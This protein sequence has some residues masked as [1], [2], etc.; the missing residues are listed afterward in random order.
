MSRPRHIGSRYALA[1]ALLCSSGCGSDRAAPILVPTGELAADAGESRYALVGE[2]VTLDGSASRGAVRYQ[3]DFGNGDRQPEPTGAPTV[4]VTFDAP[5]RYNAVL[6]VYDDAG[7]RRSDSVLITVTHPPVFAPSHSSTVAVLAG[8]DEVAVVSTDSSELTRFTWDAQGVLSLADRTATPAG[9]RTVTEWHSWLVVPCQDAGVV[10]FIPV[11]AGSSAISVTMPYGSRPY[12]AAGNDDAVFVSLSGTGQLARI[13][14]DASQTSASVTDTVDVAD[15]RGVALLPDGRVATVRWRSPDARA[16]LWAVDPATSAVDTWTLA[17]DPQPSS[18]TESGG[19][20]SYLDQLLVSP[21]G[22]E[23]VVPSLQANI[24]E[25]DF[26]TGKPLT[27]QSTV[28]AIISY[29]DPASGAEQRERRKQF[30]DRGFAAAAVFSSRGD[31]LYVAMPGAR[32]VDRIDVLGGGQSGTIL[33]V[34]YAPHGVALSSDDRYLFVDASL[35]RELVSYDVSDL[36]LPAAA[37][38]RAPI[39]AVEPLAPEVLV[40]KQLFS[41]SFDTRI[42]KDGYIA[43]AHCHLD[44]LDDRRVWDFTDRGEGLRSTISL[45]GRGGAAHGPIHW[46]SN[47][48]EVQD[49]EHDIRGPFAGTGLMSDADFHSGTRDQTLGEP[50]AGISEDLDALAAYV[51]FLDQFAPSPH[52]NGDGSLTAAAQSGKLLFESLTLGCTTCH[53]GPRLTDSQWVAPAQ[54]LLHDVG[55]LGPG[56]GQRLGGPLTGIDTPTLHGL[57]ASAPYLHDGSAA[58]LLDVLTT[59][60]PSDMHGTTSTLTQAELGDLVAYLLSL[61]GRVN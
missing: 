28:R 58:T 16:E 20:P 3:W 9:P 25:G 11:Q 14:V 39:V 45:A 56:S 6:T 32:A 13:E 29:L 26:V 57:W 44:G 10:M 60:N 5:G 34:G 35:S 46:S 53:S 21:T 52:R 55:T 30:D 54:P 43:C 12:A 1:L 22:L 4:P 37:I 18:D 24:G 47:F 40:G 15:P 41:D 33:D 48:D 27:H 23:A 31:Y 8:R 19:V 38:S 2:T 7:R 51:S 50:K 59:K 36:G 49:F 42:S 17:F 61:D